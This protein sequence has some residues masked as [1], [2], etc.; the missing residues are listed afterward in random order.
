[1]SE[2]SDTDFRAMVNQDLRDRFGAGTSCKILRR[3]ENLRRWRHE[4]VGISESIKLQNGHENAILAAHP[5]RHPTTPTRAYLL[6]KQEASDRKR[7]RLR[8]EQVALERIREIDRLIGP[9]PIPTVILGKLVGRLDEI[10]H[11]LTSGNTEKAAAQIE[12]LADYLADSA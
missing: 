6:A 9:T 1:M 12:A 11:S 7:R 8:L 3:R 2:Y 4:L 5:G 10:R